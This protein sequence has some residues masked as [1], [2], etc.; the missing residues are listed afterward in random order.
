MPGYL[1]HYSKG[2]IILTTKW[3]L[4]IWSSE[5]W[6]RIPMVPPFMTTHMILYHSNSRQKTFRYSVET[7][8]WGPVLGLYLVLW[9]RRKLVHKFIFKKLN[10]FD[11]F[12]IRVFSMNRTLRSC[13]DKF[14]DCS[15]NGPKPLPEINLKPYFQLLF[16]TK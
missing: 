7:G 11:D 12:Q 14:W 5:Y 13:P 9:G 1:V 16:L 6:T 15:D 10:I 8:C 4:E 2:W 3:H